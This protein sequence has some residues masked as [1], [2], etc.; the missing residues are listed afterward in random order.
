VVITLSEKE[1][2]G[3]VVASTAERQN[4]L[5]RWLAETCQ[6]IWRDCGGGGLGGKQR[7]LLKVGRRSMPGLGWS[8][9]LEPLS[10]G[11]AACQAVPEGTSRLPLRGHAGESS[12]WWRP[13]G[14]TR[15]HNADFREW[16]QVAVQS[17]SSDRFG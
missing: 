14:L 16:Q 12:G 5:S 6:E 17:L 3:G 13:C 7:G 11:D 4:G 9:H 1:I 15:S 10:P 2:T 8:S